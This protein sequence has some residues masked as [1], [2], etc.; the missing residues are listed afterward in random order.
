M[1]KAKNLITLLKIPHGDNGKPQEH[2]VRE[3][4]K[5]QVK[6]IKQDSTGNLYLIYPNTP[7]VCAH[8]D[9]VGTAEAQKHLHNIK[10]DSSGII[11]GTH[12]MGADDKVGIFIALEL[13]KRL[14][15][16]VSLI[17]TIAE[18]TGGIGAERFD[19]SLIDTNTYMV[20]PDRYGRTD[21]I[22]TNNDYCTEEFENAI[23]PHL[24]KFGFKSNTGVRCDADKFN[25]NIN[26]INIACGYMAHHTDNEYV[27]WQDTV[28]TIEALT[29]LMQ[30][31]IKRM[32]A[33]EPYKY[34]GMG[35]GYARSRDNYYYGD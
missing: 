5:S 12:N 10:I 23:M 26:C 33:P 2:N 15:K 11:K 17:F 28:N 25:E 3:Y 32:K 22:A 21:V 31:D 27:V 29:V 7:I 18:E 19:K 20:V 1:P 30:Q 4:I 6:G 9:N 24:G 34:L 16:K 14:G 13:H 8:M 35:Y